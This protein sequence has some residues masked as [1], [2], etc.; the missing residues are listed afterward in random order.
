MAQ[1]AKVS[2]RM[3]LSEGLRALE[4]SSR[5]WQEGKGCCKV[6]TDMW[7]CWGQPATPLL[8]PHPSLVPGS[9]SPRFPFSCLAPCSP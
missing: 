6:K 8:A 5:P 3:N 1:G 4:G 2:L 7:M 9:P